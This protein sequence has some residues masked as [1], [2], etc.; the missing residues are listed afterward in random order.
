MVWLNGD[1]LGQRSLAHNEAGVLGTGGGGGRP[2]ESL[3]MDMRSRLRRQLQRA[4][5]EVRRQLV[6]IGDLRASPPAHSPSVARFWAIDDATWQMAREMVERDLM[7]DG[8]VAGDG[9][10]QTDQE[11]MDK[12]KGL[13]IEH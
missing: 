2:Q 11:E 8:G 7:T 9:G 12:L 1:H 3:H 6:E 10:G 4:E 13:P 5:E